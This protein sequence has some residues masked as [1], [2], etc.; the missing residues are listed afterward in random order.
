MNRLQLYAF[1]EEVALIKHANLSNLASFGQKAL[2]LG[3]KALSMGGDAVY[4]GWHGFGRGADAAVRAKDGTRWLGMKGLTVGFTASQLP[5]ALKEEDPS[6]QGRSRSERIARLAGNTIGGL[7]TAG[8]LGNRSFGPK[9][10]GAMKGL[11]R[12]GTNAAVQIGVGTA[13][14]MAGEA[15]ASAPFKLL[16]KNQPAQQSSQGINNIS[17]L[18][19][20]SQQPVY[21][22]NS[23]G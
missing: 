20:Q 2:G 9:G 13:G 7:A 15:L 8:A 17:N 6:G 4:K 1:G 21:S 14:V 18:Q 23:V 11:A 19:S 3:R 12:F 10:P 16:K 22:R 5:D